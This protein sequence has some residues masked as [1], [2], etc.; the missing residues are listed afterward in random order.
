MDKYEDM[1]F[2]LSKE[3]VKT[4]NIDEGMIT[5][6]DSFDIVTIMIILFI[7][8]YSV[9]QILEYLKVLIYRRIYH[10]NLKKTKN[11]SHCLF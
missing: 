5:E 3:G 11:I 7:P 2:R 9:K 8:P 1:L 4:F 6:D 10:Q